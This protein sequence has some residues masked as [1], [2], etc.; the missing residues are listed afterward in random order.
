[1]NSLYIKDVDYSQVYVTCEYLA[2]DKFYTVN[3]YLFKE[4]I[5]CLPNYSMREFLS[6]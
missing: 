5:L 1:V 3:G 4:K 6:S 2:F